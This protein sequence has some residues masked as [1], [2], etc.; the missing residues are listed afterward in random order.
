MSEQQNVPLQPADFV[1]LHCHSYF[2]ILDGLDSPEAMASRASEMGQVAAAITDHGSCA[3]LYRFSEACKSVRKCKACS[4]HFAEKGGEC[5]R[6]GKKELE[7]VAPIKPIL[8]MESYVVPRPELRDKDE[9]RRHITIWAKDIDGYSNLIWLSTHANTNGMYDKPRISIQQL[10]EHRKGLMVG[11]ACAAG[12]LCRPILDGDESMAEK[13]ACELKDIFSDDVYVEIMSHVYHEE[14]R[15]HEARAMEAMRGALKI[16][17]RVGIKPVFTCDSHYCRRDEA[18]CHDVLLSVQ[19]RNTIKNP[20]RLTFASADFYMKSVEEVVARCGG[21]L[22]L[23]VNTKEV[24]EKVS[25]G[26]ITK[27]PFQDLLPPFKL[28]P[29]IKTEEQYLKRLI[30]DGMVRRGIYDREDCRQRILTELA[31]I[32]KLGFV[33]YFL[34]IWDVVNFAKRT[35]IRVG[36]GRGSASG[37][38]CMYCLGVTEVDPLKYGLLFERF[39]NPDR[40]SPPDVDVDYDDSKQAEMFKY[41]AD[42]YGKEFVARIG[43]YGS[44]GAKDAIRRVGKALDIGGDW[45]TSG[46]DKGAWKSGKKTLDLVDAISKCIDEKP[47]TSLKSIVESND[48]IKGFA[49]QYPKLFDIAQKMEGTIT[50]LGKHAAGIVLCNK[51]LIEMIPLRLADDGNMCSQYDMTEVEPLG[52]LKYDFLGLRNMRIIDRCLQLIKE[53]HGKEIDINALEPDDPDVFKMLNEGKVHGIFQFE[54]GDGKSTDRRG[55]PMFRTMSG[56]LLNIGVDSFNDMVACVALIR[57]G[58][59]E[60]KWDGKSVPETYCD[61]KHGRKPIKYIHPLMQEFLGETHGLMV[62]QEAVMFV[63]MKVALFTAAEADTFRKGIGKKDPILVA[64]LKQKFIDGCKR[65]EVDDA[66][67]AKIFELCESFAGYGFNKSHAVAYALIGYQ[68][69]WLKHYY[70]V[71]FMCALMTAWLGNEI[72]IAKYERVC[73][74]MGIKVLAHHIN[75]SKLEYTIEPEGIRRPL[76]SLKGIGDNSV[77]AIMACQPFSG[78][79]DF[80]GKVGGHAVNR[81]TFETLVK[82]GCMDCLGMSKSAMMSSYEEAKQK[83]KDEKKEREKEKVRAVSFGALDLFESAGV[84][85]GV[86]QKPKNQ[87]KAIGAN[88]MSS[89]SQDMPDAYHDGLCEAALGMPDKEAQESIYGKEV[90]EATDMQRQMDGEHEF[91]TMLKEDR[92]L[93][94]RS[95]DP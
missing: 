48:E 12:M 41:A 90:E 62:Y 94:A 50:S 6:C 78:L 93:E 26:L 37:S 76:T 40:V 35:G 4:Y 86:S 56:L 58:T 15:E 28:P 22:D 65:N 19:T 36:P 1:N 53:R 69:A 10:A 74:Q 83:A 46:G 20:K 87:H 79:K 85:V 47:G 60:G 2:S 80:V 61:Y 9:V 71:E 51:P 13:T 17:D 32:I 43:T 92:D 81:A 23:V 95:M 49:A 91:M 39:I 44:L 66:T 11:T 14:Q 24:A 84:D 82:I 45:E 52:L 77:K 21:R 57:P 3:G 88:G 42:K 67:A 34:V 18:A 68:N 5:P 64:S 31:A 72:K 75:K 33:R 63:A 25:G 29:G 7:K 30:K 70:P 59:L 55:L 16:A 38:L 54:G 27:K 73:D 8:G 89:V